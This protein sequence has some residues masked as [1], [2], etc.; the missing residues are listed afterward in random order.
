[1]NGHVY[2]SM[3]ISRKRHKVRRFYVPDAFE[4]TF[5]TFEEILAREK[6][7]LSSWLRDNAEHYVRLHE[8]GNPQQRID[9]IMKL[10]KAY[11]AESPICGFKDCLRDSVGIG[12]FLPQ[13][14]TYNVCALHMGQVENDSVNWKV[15][16]DNR[17]GR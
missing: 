5:K 13:K 7:S 2:M 8:P 15:L 14:K 11:H 10:G 12:L 1:M 9:I 3:S 4:D 17:K 6:K 16:E